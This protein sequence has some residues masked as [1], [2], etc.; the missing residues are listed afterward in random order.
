MSGHSK[1]ATTKRAKESKDAKRSH[2]FTKLS[3]NISVAARDGAD[4][5]ANF[6]LRMAIDKAKTLS[7]PKENIERAINKGS[8]QTDGQQIESLFYEAYGPEGAALLVEVLTDNKNRTVSNLKHILGKHNG[9]LGSN[10]SVMWMFE[11]K[12]EI[13]IN[14]EKLSEEEEL[15]VIEAGADDIFSD[16]ETK[17]IVPI[18]QLQA[19]KDKIQAAGFEVS[20]SEVVYLAKDKIIPQEPEKLISLLDALDEDDDINNIFTNA[21]V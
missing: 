6:K 9:S 7:M 15:K 14:K 2:L 18:D 12:G 5:E 8:G 20:S 16:G 11:P 19:A 17:I 4:P 21:D 1:W 10:G 3:K 13:I